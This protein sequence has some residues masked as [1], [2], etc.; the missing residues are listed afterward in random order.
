MTK[1]KILIFT[2]T[3]ASQINGAKITLEELARNS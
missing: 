2:D 1:K 3:Y